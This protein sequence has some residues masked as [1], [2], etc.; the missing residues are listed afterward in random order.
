MV[1]QLKQE[2]HRLRVQL[3]STP[4]PMRRTPP[5]ADTFAT[6]QSSSPAPSPL[7]SPLRFGDLNVT[8]TPFPSA[9]PTK[10]S[11]KYVITR[12]TKRKNKQTRSISTTSAS[13]HLAPVGQ[14]QQ[15]PA[16]STM[17]TLRQ[18]E[19]DL[20]NIF[21]HFS[22]CDASIRDVALSANHAMATA[23]SSSRKYFWEESQFKQF[24]RQFEL[25][26]L[27]GVRASVDLFQ[28]HATPPDN[29]AN[30]IASENKNRGG[31]RGR[32]R[33]SGNKK[34]PPGCRMS[35]SQFMWCLC[36]LCNDLPWAAGATP[37]QRASLFLVGLDKGLLTKIAMTRSTIRIARPKRSWISKKE[38]T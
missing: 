10:S 8:Q 3:C 9:S 30:G 34:T 35:F 18:R 12:R 19:N 20:C 6:P 38:T 23:L 2:N 1:R 4:T 17:D 16:A 36:A 22:Q 5:G 31:A 14:Y 33:S 7:P 26:S 29:A 15:Q 24:L 21:L 28:L 25:L 11:I 27:F 37:Q 13:A 32:P